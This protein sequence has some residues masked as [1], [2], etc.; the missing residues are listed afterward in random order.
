MDL[1]PT[2]KTINEMSELTGLAKHYLRQLVLQNKIVHVKAGKKFLIN[3]EKFFEF[4]NKGEC[5][6]GGTTDV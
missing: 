2:M 3:A 4:L 6:C 5:N 1:I